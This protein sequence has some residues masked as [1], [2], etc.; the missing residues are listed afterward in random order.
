[1]LQA[2]RWVGT[3][4]NKI[5]IYIALTECA[6]G[7]FIKGGLPAK[8]IVV[9]PNFVEV[10]PGD[11]DGKQGSYVLFVGRLTREKGLGTLLKAWESLPRNI[12]LYVIGDGPIRPELQQQAERAGMTVSFLGQQSHAKVQE[13]MKAA[14]FVVFP[15]EWPEQFG[16]VAIESFA[17]SVPVIS[18]DVKALED[19][20]SNE[21]TG[22]VFRSADSADLAEK[23]LYAWNN[24]DHMRTLG[25]NARAEYLD[26]YAAKKNLSMLME[27]YERAIE[28]RAARCETFSR[29]EAA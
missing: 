1:M 26:K 13:L 25:Q 9:K 4:S 3:W 22:L 7:E 17:C 8:K 11:H 24:P 15:S 23:V 6:R 12:P 28:F 27:I 18:S 19:I 5:D 10:D 2:H 21:R 29:S 14:L 20:V 16:L